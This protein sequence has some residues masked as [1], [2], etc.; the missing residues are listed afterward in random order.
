[1]EGG[2]GEA[3]ADA[4]EAEV[5]AGRAVDLDRRVGGEGE[6]VGGEADDQARV[7]GQQQVDERV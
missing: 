6:A 7:L 4:V 2:V 1:M 3:V 5:D